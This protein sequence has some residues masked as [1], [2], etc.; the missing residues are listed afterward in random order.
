MSDIRLRKIES[1]LREEISLLILNGKIK[2]PR[3][4]PF[5]TVT[6]VK[7]SRD[8]SYAKIYLSSFEIDRKLESAVEAMNHAAGFIQREVG[9]KLQT[10][11]TPRLTFIKDTSIKD[12]FEVNRKIEELNAQA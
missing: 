6:Q 10:R 12:G 5:I 2:D 8:L 11:T 9:K 7:S 1:L 3:V 4:T